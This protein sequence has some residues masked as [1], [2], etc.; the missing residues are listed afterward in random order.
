MLAGVA[1]TADARDGRGRPPPEECAG[2]AV[3][4][5]LTVAVSSVPAAAWVRVTVS[6]RDRA[7]AHGQLGAIAPPYTCTGVAC[8]TGG[9]VFAYPLPD[10]LIVS[11]RT[12]QGITRQVVVPQYHEEF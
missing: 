1:C 12:A 10:T 8:Q 9:R 11:L 6:A 5:A 3:P 2:V 4:S 7:A